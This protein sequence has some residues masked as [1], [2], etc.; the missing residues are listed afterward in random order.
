MSKPVSEMSD[1]EFDVALEAMRNEPIDDVVEEEAPPEAEEPMQDESSEEETVANDSPE[2]E[3][4]EEDTEEQPE[5]EEESDVDG[6]DVTP[7]AEEEEEPE[8]S[9]VTQE[10]YDFSKVPMDELLPIDIPANGIKVKATMN[11]L[12]EG[13][14]KGM[15]YTQKMQELSEHRKSI[16]ILAE[17]GLNETDLGLL[18]DA[19]GG[20]KEAIAK[21]LSDAK[22]DPL[23]LDLE[24]KANYIAKDYSKDEVDPEMD[25]VRKE[26]LSDTEYSP[27]VEDAIKTMP[28]DMF[29]EVAGN[30]SNLNALYKDV[31]SGMYQKV[32]PEVVKIKNL[33]GSTKSTKDL[34][35]EVARNMAPTMAQPKAVPV[36]SKEEKESK[37]QELNDKRKKAVSSSAAANKP[38]VIKQDLDELDDA[39]FA[40]EFAKITGRSVNEYK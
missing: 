36:P 3:E 7:E 37:R 12:I 32:M 11:E 1:E 13:F 6:D 35:I 31:K 40:K 21:L 26:I 25:Y 18:I 23:D 34:Y 33:Y 20:N 10:S 5:G 8:E 29:R 28:E 38:S 17:H 15:N 16:S 27:I 22:I 9:E 14:K 24:A 2:K 39:A 19:R 30:A 4:G